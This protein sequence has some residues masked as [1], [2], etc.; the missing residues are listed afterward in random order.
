MN[1]FP[2]KSKGELH[3]FGWKIFL[4]GTVFCASYTTPIHET[5]IKAKASHL[6]VVKKIKF[7]AKIALTS[8][9]LSFITHLLSDKHTQVQLY[10]LRYHYLPSPYT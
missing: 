7:G 4:S 10:S 1:D 9:F 3:I 8:I 6:N 5:L 2:N